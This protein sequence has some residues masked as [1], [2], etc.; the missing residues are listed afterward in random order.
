MMRTIPNL[1]IPN[2]GGAAAEK[3][4][5][6]LKFIEPMEV[7]LLGAAFALLRK[8]PPSLYLGEEWL[9]GTLYGESVFP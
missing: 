2:L 9:V 5:N 7:V 1:D 8:Q 4:N 3:S 6:S